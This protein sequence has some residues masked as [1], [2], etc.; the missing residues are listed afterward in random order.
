MLFST[1]RA[2]IFS[3]FGWFYFIINPR[4]ILKNSGG[5]YTIYTTQL[6]S[7]LFM[8]I[9]KETALKSFNFS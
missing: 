6:I 7:G 9:I 2:Q 1:N 5:V 4:S 8:L 3:T